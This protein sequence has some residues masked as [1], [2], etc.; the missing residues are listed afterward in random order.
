VTG[1]VEVKVE[2]RTDDDA[3]A[4]VIA[5]TQRHVIDSDSVLRHLMQ[6]CVMVRVSGHG[7]WTYLDGT[8]VVP[9][10]DEVAE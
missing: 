9:Q 3:M 10:P 6:R 8:G 2:A 5:L 4:M 1:S 7:G